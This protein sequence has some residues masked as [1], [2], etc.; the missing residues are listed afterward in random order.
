MARLRDPDGGC[1][2]DLAQ[3]FSTIVPHTLEEAYEV[4]DAIERDDMDDLKDELGDLLFQVV[5]YAQL[6]KEQDMF[7]FEQVAQAIGEKLLRRHPHVF[8]DAPNADSEAVSNA[9]EAL[10]E[11]ER[12]DKHRGAGPVSALDGVPVAF[13]A[14]T[15][16]RK[17]QKRAART[18]FD[19]PGSAAVYD[20]IAEEASELRE[21]VDG[22]QSQAR[23]EEELGDL[24]FTVVNLSRHLSADPESALRAA[25]RKFERRFRAVE[26]RLADSGRS[27]GS[28]SLEE[29]DATWEEVKAAE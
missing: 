17:L 14:L 27:P 4:A 12:E 19:W 26:Q 1:P 18:G 6:A 5:F 25:N 2:W 21:A 10:K 11:Q 23:I 29:L 20:K 8:G 3:D 7:D 28:C 22:Q 13:P 16:A 15:R 24:L 9:W